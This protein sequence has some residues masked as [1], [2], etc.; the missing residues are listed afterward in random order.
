MK[1]RQDVENWTPS[2]VKRRGN[3]SVHVD[4][5]QPRGKLC[6]VVQDAGYVN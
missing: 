5:V 6:R 2:P 4:D 3:E 1:K